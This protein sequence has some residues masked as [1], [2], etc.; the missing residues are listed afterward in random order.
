MIAVHTSWYIYISVVLHM[1]K[2][3]A[4]VQYLLQNKH[5]YITYAI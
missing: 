1:K 2:E 5:T 3:E 4:E